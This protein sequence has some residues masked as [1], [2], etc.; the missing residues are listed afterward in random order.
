MQVMDY[1]NIALSL[2]VVGAVVECIVILFGYV[3]FFIF[4]MF[5]KGGC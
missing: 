5:G 3:F 2:M 4:R 1:L